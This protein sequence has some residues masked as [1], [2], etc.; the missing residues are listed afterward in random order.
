MRR[1]A[2]LVFALYFICS[3]F[4]VGQAIQVADLRCE[5]LNDPT[6]I[7]TPSPR[8]SWTVQSSQR[9]QRQTACQ[10]AV[11]DSLEA[12]DAAPANL[13]QM[14]KTATDETTQVLYRGRPLG[15]RQVC[16]WKV[17]AW[18]RDGRPSQWSKPARWEMG[19][20]KPEDWKAKWIEAKPPA[21]AK[22]VSLEGAKWIWCPERG[23]DLAKAAPVGE[24]FFRCR[25]DVPAERPSR[26]SIVIEV[27]D[28]YTLFVNGRRIAHVDAA[29]GW[30]RPTRY[31]I[32]P[33]LKSGANVIAVAGKNLAAQAGVCAKITIQYPGKRPRTIVSDRAWKTSAASAEGWAGPGF[34]DSQWKNSFEIAPFGQGVWQ[35]VAPAASPQPVPILRRA[36]KLADKPIASAR[37]YVTALGL[38]EIHINGHRVGDQ[39]LAPDWT[40]YRKR[41]RYQVYDVTS[42]LK[43]GDNAIAALL[44]NGWYCGHIGNG[45]FHFFG[46]TPA[47]MTQLEVTYADGA[48]ERIVSDASWKTHASPILA[49]DFFLG[50][51]YD[52]NKEIAGWDLPELD[53][54]AWTHA[55]VREEPARKIEGQVMQPVRVLAEIKPKAVT[56]PKAGQSVFDMGQNMVGFARLTVSAPKGTKITLRHAEMLNPDGTIYTTNLRDA[57]SIDTYICKGTGTETWQPTFTFH[58][59]RYVEL[60]GLPITRHVPRDEDINIVTGVVIGTDTPHAGE[61]SCSGPRLNQLQKNIQWGQRGNYVSIP[62]D[63]P[64]RD[65]RLGWMG[66]AQVFVR[67]ATTNADVAA[68]FTKWLVDV[69]D[70]QSPD[71]AFGDVSPTTMGGKG[72][73]AW[74]DA[75]VICPWTIYQV[76][77]DRRILAQHLPAMTRWVEW[78]RVHSTGLIRDRDRGGDY[79]DWLSIG[80]DTPK[81]LIGTA[82]FAYST[83][84]LARS[85]RA[86]GDEANAAKYERLFREIK[87]AFIKRYVKPDGRI[88]GNTQC[89]YAM[90]LKFN[91]LPDDLRPKAVK[92][93]E[94]D[95]RAKDWHLSTGFVGVSYLLPVLTQAGKIDTAYRLLTQDTFP[96]WLFS[97]KHG[98]TTIWER[99]DGWTPEHGFQNPGMNSFN[100]YALG[101]CGQWL[102]DTVAGIGLD[103]DQ[104]GYKHIIIHP[105]VGGG[106]TWARASLR[107]TH[108]PIESAWKLADGGLALDV[109]IPANTTAVIYVPAASADA[110][111]ES[112][113]PAAKAEG[114]KLL[115]TAHGEAV[116]E[117]QSGAYHF[118][119]RPMGSKAKS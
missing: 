85:Y 118:T 11:A 79:G 7:D 20:L 48:T 41:V 83:D 111:Q 99:W 35:N 67:T 117:I 103:P 37:L 87:A 38:Y 109:T 80:A 26:A 106:L 45:G 77:G 54:A 13:W 33:E 95:I 27:D 30:R 14:D 73:P 43:S 21:E 65:E 6:G 66:D 93:L 50:E 40:D 59:F 4:A 3:G 51:S 105:H 70:G 17:R 10:V 102:F 74:A 101:S 9:G 55:E 34:D 71:G 107:S 96:S 31:D 113:K 86:V 18:D 39:A 29:D 5:S 98:A 78:C 75:G 22:A 19:L 32:L 62:T 72:T 60:T 82:Y 24:R 58:G 61:F 49:S 88:H 46:T 76:Y 119:A 16:Y 116:F 57:P 112:G 44:G 23:V 81:D 28:Q 68:F 63:C 8:L 114:V 84:L 42:M 90:A 89:C 52:A 91:L 2:A 100:H 47:L 1:L 53:D 69:D 94:D 104:P 115:R 64:Q 108:G 56:H 25:L 97:V 15:S 12:L 36:F 92:Y 110:V